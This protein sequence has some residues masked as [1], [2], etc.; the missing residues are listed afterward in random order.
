MVAIRTECAMI[1]IVRVI[2]V[3][4]NNLGG[5]KVYAEGTE[6]NYH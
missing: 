2:F 3:W 1:G 6:E 5:G 4:E